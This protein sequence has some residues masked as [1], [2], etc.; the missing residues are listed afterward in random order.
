MQG[1]DFLFELGCEELPPTSL[2]KFSKA[3][4]SNID[5]ALA[6]RTMIEFRR[7]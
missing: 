2:L 6:T 7:M 3:L 5:A 4:K 1:N